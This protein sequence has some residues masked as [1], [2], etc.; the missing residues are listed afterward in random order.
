MLSGPSSTPQPNFKENH[1]YSKSLM[2]SLFFKISDTIK[3]LTSS[4]QADNDHY[5]VVKRLVATSPHRRQP[6]YHPMQTFCFDSASFIVNILTGQEAKQLHKVTTNDFFN[7]TK[8]LFSTSTSSEHVLFHITHGR[9]HAF[10]IEKKSD[11]TTTWWRVYQSQMGAFSLAEWLG[12]DKWPLSPEKCYS[13]QYKHC[14]N[15]RK[16]TD[17]GDLKSCIRAIAPPLSGNSTYDAKED[18]FSVAV[19]AVDPLH[20]HDTLKPVLQKQMLSKTL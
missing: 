16:L 15:G 17:V 7:E 19:L 8:Q 11:P 6:A 20:C 2:H 13:M 9:A 10:V 18:I 4:K 3:H 14:G 12:I 1:A 5:E